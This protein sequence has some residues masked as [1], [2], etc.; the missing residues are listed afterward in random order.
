MNT[1]LTEFY[2]VFGSVVSWFF[3]TMIINGVSLGGIII[4]ALLSS[5]AATYIVMK[6]KVVWK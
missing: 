3:S 6:A 4:A 2:S 1:V 5:L